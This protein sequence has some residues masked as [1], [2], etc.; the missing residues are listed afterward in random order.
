MS[1]SFYNANIQAKAARDAAKEQARATAKATQKQIEND[2]AIRRGTAARL[3][4]CIENFSDLD[5][6]SLFQKSD[7]ELARFQAEHPP[8]SPQ[9]AL[10]LNEWNRRLV[11]RQVK[12][13]K[14]SA[15]MGLIGIILGTFL[16]WILASY[17]FKESHQQLIEHF[18]QPQVENP[19]G[20]QSSTQHHRKNPDK[21]T[22][23]SE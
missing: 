6:S 1:Q 23:Y 17:S 4:E 8:E 16:G 19:A 14:F 9:Y 18:S 22:P 10:S 2:D 12:A 11:T 13:T 15:L 20:K 21:I 5:E 3:K 7:K